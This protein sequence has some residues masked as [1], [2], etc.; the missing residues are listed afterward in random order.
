QPALDVQTTSVSSMGNF[1]TAH[2]VTFEVTQTGLT[3]ASAGA[4]LAALASSFTANFLINGSAISNVTLT[5]YADANN[6]AFGRSQLLSSVSYSSGPTNAS[7]AL[8]SNPTLNNSLFSETVV[9]TA[10]FTAAG[11]TLNADAQIVAVPEPASLALFGMGLLGM[12]L[13]R[14]RKSTNTPA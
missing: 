3:S 7:G 2:T 5:T 10:T 11:A 8:I 1:A 9:I 6:T 12:G 13:V 14:S 4:P